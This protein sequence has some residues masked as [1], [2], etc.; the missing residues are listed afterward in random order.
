MLYK[1]FSAELLHAQLALR[2]THHRGITN[3]GQHLD[4]PCRNESSLPPSAL[5]LARVCTGIVFSSYPLV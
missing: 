3:L 2:K 5:A 1:L 4:A